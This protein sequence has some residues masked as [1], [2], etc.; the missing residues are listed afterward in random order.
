MH[1]VFYC[2]GLLSTISLAFKPPTLD[3]EDKSTDKNNISGLFINLVITILIVLLNTASLLKLTGENY[4]CVL[5]LTTILNCILDVLSAIA[6]AAYGAIILLFSLLIT[7]IVNSFEPTTQED[8]DN[9]QK[10]KRFTLF[11]TILSIVFFILM[12]LMISLI[13]MS[14]TACD[15]A[16]D[17]KEKK[18]AK[19]IIEY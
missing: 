3:P 4:S 8:K 13:V 14:C 7:A 17:L 6:Y 1:L 12:I 19:M 16:A 11:M 9:I 5:N 10:V 15:A 18:E 2:L